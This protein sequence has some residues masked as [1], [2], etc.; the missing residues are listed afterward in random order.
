[1]LASFEDKLLLREL[2]ALEKVELSSVWNRTEKSLQRHTR[3]AALPSLEIHRRLTE[4]LPGETLL[5]SASMF[6]D[7]LSAAE[8]FFHLSFK[9][10]KSKLGRTLDVGESELVLRA[11]RAVAAASQVLNGFDA[12]RRYMHTR[13]FALGGRT[14]VDLLRTAE[15][16]RLVLNELHAQ[17]EGGPL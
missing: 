10:I 4:G 13:N 16:E 8:D 12:A 17:A 11:A 5:M 9:T 1:M 6:L 3:S 2:R 14:P 15:G 7:T